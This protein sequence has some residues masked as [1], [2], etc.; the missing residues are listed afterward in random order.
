MVAADRDWGDGWA[1]WYAFEQQQAAKSGDRTVCEQLL[2][3]V[4]QVEPRHGALWQAA[5]KRPGHHRMTYEEVLQQVAAQLQEQSHDGVPKGA[6][7]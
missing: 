7:T 3:K 2:R 4:A 5:R 1:W 6:A